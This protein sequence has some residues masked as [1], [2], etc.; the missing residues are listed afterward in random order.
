MAVTELA[1]HRLYQYFEETMGAERATTLMELLPP[2]GWAD[3][4]TKHDL[5]HLATSAELAEV[6]AKL[7]DLRAELKAEMAELRTEL[8]TEIERLR[9]EMHR[10][11]RLQFGAIVTTNMALAA[12]VVSLLR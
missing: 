1:R 7:A 4:A 6:R 8:R 3:V 12:I 10:S 9:G 2:V 11:G 5:A